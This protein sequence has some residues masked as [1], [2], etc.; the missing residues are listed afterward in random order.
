MRTG[1]AGMLVVHPGTSPRGRT[2]ST[3]P[4]N[5]TSPLPGYLTARKERSILSSMDNYSYG[6]DSLE[7]AAEAR[8][9]LAE[10]LYT[11][12]WYHPSLGLLLGVLV[13]ELGGT[14]GR[15]GLYLMPVPALG[16]LA[17]GR[18]YRRLSGIDLYGSEAP[19]GGRRGRS[20]LAIYV[21]TLIVCFAA[22]FTLGNQLGLG[23]AAWVV[24]SLVVVGTV[25]VGRTYDRLLRAE[26]E[27]T[28]S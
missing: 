17:L 14:F 9:R 26:L 20:L 12:W 6:N 3:M 11:P 27:G 4:S 18:I 1:E 10:R 13:L 28:A 2:D 8:R 24:A 23:W 25:G 19:D 7:A 15:P 22:T 16:I 5:R 21:S